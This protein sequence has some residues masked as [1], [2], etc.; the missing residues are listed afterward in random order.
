MTTAL[1]VVAAIAFVFEVAGLL[2]CAI[3]NLSF[4]RAFG[5]AVFVQISIPAVFIAVAVIW[6][7]FSPTSDGVEPF[8]GTGIAQGFQLYLVFLVA[9]FAATLAAGVL[10]FCQIFLRANDRTHDA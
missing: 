5:S 6:G 7:H 9:G 10:G 1:L 4:G 8:A 2:Y 3:R